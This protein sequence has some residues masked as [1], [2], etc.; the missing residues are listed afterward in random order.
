MTVNLINTYTPGAN[1]NNL[2]GIAGVRFTLT[3][4]H[5]YNVTQL[6]VR[7]AT[8][9]SGNHSATLYDYLGNIIASTSSINLTGGTVG[10]FIYAA[11]TAATLIGGLVYTLV[12]GVSNGGQNWSDA[13]AITMND[14]GS[15]VAVSGANFAGLSAGTANQMFAGVDMVF[16]ASDNIVASKLKTVT[17]VQP[18][19]QVSKLKTVVVVQIPV[20]VSKL[21][22]VVV[23]LAQPAPIPKNLPQMVHHRARK[24]PRPTMLRQVRGRYKSSFPIQV[25]HRQHHA[26]KKM[27]RPTTLTQLRRRC[28]FAG[29]RRAIAIFMG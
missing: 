25:P 5:T 24:M 26:A 28:T 19:I 1:R 16:T 9:N 21:K 10:N 23:L 6:G 8:G 22:T 20:Q 17:V 12:T 18:P 15:I 27:A 13:G 29:V 11:V 7:M 14:A 3:A 2:T 4:G